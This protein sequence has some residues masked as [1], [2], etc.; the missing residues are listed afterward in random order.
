MKKPE[1]HGIPVNSENTTQLDPASGP[2]KSELQFNHSHPLSGPR[3]TGKPAILHLN[4][5]QP[6]N[7]PLFAAKGDDTV[8]SRQGQQS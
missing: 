5:N 6:A 8:M 3:P 2:T 7:S 1:K 4:H